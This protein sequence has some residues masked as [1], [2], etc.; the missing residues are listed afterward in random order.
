MFGFGIIRRVALL[1]CVML[2]TAAFALA[3]SNEI[4]PG[5]RV[6]KIRLGMT[7][8]S[9]HRTLGQ[10]QGVF[11]LQR[12]VAGDYWHSNATGDALQI[13]Y[14]AGKVFQIEITS[15]RFST[16]EGLTTESSLREVRKAYG[17]LRKTAYF[18]DNTGGTT[19]NYYEAAGRGI[20]FMFVNM[21]STTDPGNFKPFSIIVH[22]RGQSAVTA[23]EGDSDSH[24]L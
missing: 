2:G 13:S 8:Q 3:Q 6:G 21:D 19:V 22:A 17:P 4:E 16:P 12:G 1:S 24:R 10:P 14:R 7:R 11:S 5:N 18:R 15:N 9:V 20:T 23:D